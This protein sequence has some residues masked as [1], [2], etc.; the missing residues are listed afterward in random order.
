MVNPGEVKT[1][2][3]VEYWIE[4]DGYTVE[5]KFVRKYPHLFGPCATDPDHGMGDIELDDALAQAFRKIDGYGGFGSTSTERH[6]GGTALMIGNN[7]VK[8]SAD[9]PPVPRFWISEGQYWLLGITAG[10]LLKKKNLAEATTLA[11][12]TLPGLLEDP[13]TLKRI[14][15]IA[16]TAMAAGAIAIPPLLQALPGLLKT[17]GIS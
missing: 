6:C 5:M 15:A 9:I 3:G 1:I 8:S 10:R 13:A 16:G 17:I 4:P 7:D 11:L 12:E 14:T 2:G